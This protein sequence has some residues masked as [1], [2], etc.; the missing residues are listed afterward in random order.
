MNN[1]IKSLLIKEAVGRR[2]DLSVL[3]LC[4]GMG[5]D[6]EKWQKVSIGHYVGCDLSRNSVIEAQ[7]RHESMCK[8]ALAYEGGRNQQK[9]FSAIFIVSDASN[10]D[11][12]SVD[13]ILNE[14]QKKMHIRDKIVF[15]VVSTQFAIHYM[16]ECEQKLRG[17]LENVT[18]RLVDGG[19]FIGT[20]IDSDRLVHKIR[21]SGR[22]GN[23]TIGNEYFSIVFGQDNFRRGNGPFGLKYYFYLADAIG[24]R[25]ASGPILYVDEYLVP[26]DTLVTVAKE[27][28]LELDKKVNFHEYFD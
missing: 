17:Y 24:K 14:E 11:S 13:A 28:G 26:F 27:Y 3:D 9:S 6:L 10:N 18:K 2:K 16:F 15:D 1:F 5:G 8:R 20:T 23:L 21:E 19:V 7:S 25:M 4:C 22:E 12:G